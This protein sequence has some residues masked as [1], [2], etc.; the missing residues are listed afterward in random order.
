[1]LRK[2]F[3]TLVIVTLMFTFNFETTKVVANTN[4]DQPLIN[5]KGKSSLLMEYTTGKIIFAKNEHEKMYPASMT[6]MVGMHLVLNAIK[7]GK[8][9]WEDDVQVSSKAASMGGT[10]IFLQPGE[11]MKVKDLFKSVAINSANDA[12]FALG[13][14]VGGSEENFIKMMND[15]VREIGLKNTNFANIVGFDDENHYSTA[16]DMAIIGRTL[17]GHGDTILNF[18]K[19][20]DSYVREDT[21][22]PFWLVNTNKLVKFYNGMDG[23]KTGFTQK[24]KYCLTA[25]AKRDNLRFIAV[26][27]G[28]NTI[29]ERSQDITTMLNYGF[30]NYSAIKVYQQGEV[31]DTLHIEDAKRPKVPIIVTDNIYMVV[32]KGEKLDSLKAR[33]EYV[34]NS[35]P[36]AEREVVGKLIIKNSDNWEARFDVVT[37]VKVE[38]LTFWDL[39]IKTL[40]ECLF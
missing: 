22:S 14:L 6:K 8:I 2:I 18:T 35:S 39:F 36:I 1:M 11:V 7:D 33:I 9:D 10:Q 15:F 17:L 32:R 16:Y 27:M 28:N 30:A 31:I 12:M 40:Q 25:T 29:Q 20:Y 21:S 5:T 4:P 26:S 23:L 34:K 13:E 3:A 19:I 37:A 38:Q 24:S